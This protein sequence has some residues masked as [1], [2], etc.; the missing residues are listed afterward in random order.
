MTELA[1]L[2]PDSYEVSRLRFRSQLERL[3]ARWPET[4]LHTQPL[5]VDSQLTTDWFE[6][7]AGHSPQRLLIVTTG[8]HGIE[9]YV[10]S[11]V[12]QVI[13]EDYLDRLDPRSTG[14]LLLHAVN[15]WGMR[16]RRRTNP[17]NVDL[18]R[19][20][21]AAA[22]HL[23]P[24]LNPDYAR[25]DRFL[26][27]A[28]PLA[29]PVRGRREF[30]AGLLAG[31]ARMGPKAFQAVT[32][33]GQYRNPRGLYFGGSTIQAET[34]LLI[35]L[36]REAPARYGRV[37]CLDMHTGYGP[38]DQMTLVNSSLEPRASIDLMRAFDYP[39]VAKATLAEFY[40]IRGD[41]IDLVYATFRDRFPGKPVFA[42]AF[43]FG[44]LGDSLPARLRGLRAMIWEN[45]VHHFG[46]SSVAVQ[47]AVRRE[48]EALFCPTHPP[49]RRK[50]IAD[51]RR[52]LE[53]ILRV[54]GFLPA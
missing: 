23:D 33:Q 39:R 9:G 34:R 53:G 40:P 29:G 14:V 3:R 16:N 30:L 6:S 32:L 1:A 36:Y 49:W 15:P 12:L 22:S 41:M 18:N 24:A 21:V 44:T 17:A 27:P 50:A 28:R 2:F 8:E 13:L 35:D 26:N 4:R 11:A 54:E 43:E 31:L 46:A 38:S 5:E 47:R 48:F 42:T 51:A 7:P 25:L 20:F 45:Q 37:L 52:A 10:G 19:N